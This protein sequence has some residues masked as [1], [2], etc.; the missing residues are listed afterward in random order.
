MPEKD[1]DPLALMTQG[2]LGYLVAI[3]PNREIRFTAKGLE[4]ARKDL[5]EDMVLDLEM[6][7]DSMRL[8]YRAKLTKVEDTEDES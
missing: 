8:F 7:A 3:S 4:D 1:V 5:G 2:L 6:D